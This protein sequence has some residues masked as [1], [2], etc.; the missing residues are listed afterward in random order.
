MITPSCSSFPQFPPFSPSCIIYIKLSI[1]R[2]RGYE[3]RCHWCRAYR[4]DFGGEVREG[5]SSGQRGQFE[6]EGSRLQRRSAQRLRIFLKSSK[7]RMSSFWR[8]LFLPLRRFPGIFS[9]MQERRSWW[10]R[11]I[12]IRTSVIPIS[13][14]WTKEK[15]KASWLHC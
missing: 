2:R 14:N 10:I 11:P 15:Q 7:E 6:R 1:Y 5:R 4:R 8:F 9:R 13:R 12:I 3:Y